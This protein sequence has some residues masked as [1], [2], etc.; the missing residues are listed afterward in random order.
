MLFR[1]RWCERGYCED[2]LDWDRTELVGEN[3]K[4]YVLLGFP[5]V[6]RA[7]YVKCPSCMAHHE[8][9]EEARAFCEQAATEIDTK[10]DGMMEEQ[11]LLA[12]A[13]VLEASIKPKEAPSRAESL[14]MTDAT[15]ISNSGI[16]TPL[17]TELDKA[18]VTDGKRKAAP[19]SFKT[20]PTKRSKRLT[21]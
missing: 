19:F 12:A 17:F 6:N 9:N 14:T 18:A 5:A 4:E 2:C 7:F 21:A 3:L 13:P 20:T 10:Y 16:N 8:E 11:A 1:C 15:T